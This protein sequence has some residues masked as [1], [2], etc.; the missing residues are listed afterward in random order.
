MRV[1]VLG[2]GAGG[3]AAV[4]ELTAAGHEVTLW[5]RSDATLEPLRRAGGVEFD[6]V[7]GEGTARPRLLT[8]DLAQSLG[9]CEAVVCVLPTFLHAALAGDL[10]QAGL[11]RDVPIVLNPG[12][13]GGAL[14]FRT[15]FV[16]RLEA[17]PPIA[18]L[19]T[20]TWVARKH[21]PQR[22][23]VTGR[24]RSVRAAALPG[25][26]R[27]L[28]SAC[29]LFPSARAQPDVLASD[30][31]NVNMVLHP[32]G[33]VLGAAWIEATHGDFTFYVEGM[34]SG[35]AR[36]MRA[37][38][39]E[40]RAVAAAYGHALPNLIEEMQLI[41]TVE[42]AVADTGDFASAIAGGRAN[43]RI[44][45]PDSLGHRYYREDFGHGLLPFIELARIA[46][47]PVPV[48]E[49]LL[50]LGERLLGTDFRAS[51]RTAQAMGIAGL[52]REGL[53]SLVRA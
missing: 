3:C 20:L 5:N 27:A 52:D 51:G 33:A 16:R 36:V 7:L 43:S 32:P 48:A 11:A 25:G 1:T 35:V 44:R 29:I 45:A 4:A 50:T 19:S 23:T 46:A 40:R 39:D 34:T 21:A 6:G 49:S 26:E 28:E 18:E 15:A 17:V 38:D 30:L 31:A 22:V 13:T 10:A 53:I 47:V 8:S 24:A 2:A 37:L 14:E 12:H 42:A 9:G 41:G